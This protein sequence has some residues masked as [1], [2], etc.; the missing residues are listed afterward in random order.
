MLTLSFL[1]FNTRSEPK[2]D[3]M[4]R[5]RSS[6]PLLNFSLASSMN[7]NMSS[8]VSSH[9]STRLPVA[10]NNASNFEG[11][12]YWL[13]TVRIPS[14][15]ASKYLGLELLVYLPLVIK[16]N[17]PS[18]YGKG[19]MCFGDQAVCGQRP[20]LARWPMRYLARAPRSP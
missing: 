12:F 17:T 13:K 16:K 4:A 7:V 2:V 9:L 15:T 14:Q 5:L 19:E 10:L 6:V 20:N 8:A 18:N 3:K 1:S 11:L